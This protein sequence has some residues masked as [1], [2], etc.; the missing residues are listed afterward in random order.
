MYVNR[1]DE[2]DALQDVC[3]Q[4]GRFEDMIHPD[5]AVVLNV[6][7][8]YSS[9]VAMQLAH[10]LSKGG[11][12]L[13]MVAVD[14]AW[15]DEDSAKYHKKFSKQIT[16]L[17]KY[18]T[19]ILVEAGVITGRNYAYMHKELVNA[20]Y[21][22]ITVALYESEKSEFKSDVVGRYYDPEAGELEFYFETYNKHWDTKAESELE[23]PKYTLTRERDSLVRKGI[24]ISWVEWDEKGNAKQ[25]H[26][27]I[28]VGR[29]LLLDPQYAYS[30]TWLTTEVTEILEESEYIV[31]FNT[32][33]S[34]YTLVTSPSKA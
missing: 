34:T 26:D 14:V 32:K 21:N 9:T 27:S 30:Y 16:K 2:W 6:S 25:M 4:M 33:N 29:S 22:V 31:K 5:N 11:E 24:N 20:G 19:V 15:P 1:N 28:A 8:D 23:T 17:L 10:Y 7:P 3:I 18:K 13:N 12:M